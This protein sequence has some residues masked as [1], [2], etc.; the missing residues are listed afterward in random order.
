MRR[1]KCTEYE[2]FFASYSLSKGQERAE[3]EEDEE[4]TEKLDTD[5]NLIRGLLRSRKEPVAKGFDKDAILKQ[6]AE[7][8]QKRIQGT[9]ISFLV[10]DPPRGR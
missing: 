6:L 5:F 8:T 10:A 1:V 2:K 9:N 7:S 4:L 3:R